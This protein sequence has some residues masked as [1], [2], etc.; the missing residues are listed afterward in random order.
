MERS[1]IQNRVKSVIASVL[2]IDES[3]I[4]DDTNFIF[5]LG[6]DSMQSLELVAAFEEEFDV[7][8]D[9]DKALEVQTVSDAVGFIGT[10]LD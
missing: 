7:E 2:E 4:G 5:D 9:E 6:A 8:M 1:E 10:Y 3:T